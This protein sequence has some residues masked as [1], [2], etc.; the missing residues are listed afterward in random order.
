MKKTYFKYRALVT[1]LISFLPGVYSS[2][3]KLTAAG[4]GGTGAAR[5]CLD[6]WLSHLSVASKYGLKEIPKSI[7]ELGPG[8]SLGAGLSA[9]LLGAE[10]YFAMDLMPYSQQNTN[11]VVLN[12]L[13]ALIKNQK[14][15]A[16]APAFPE[17]A[18]NLDQSLWP[19]D[20]FSNEKF[21][22]LLSQERLSKIERALDN[23]NQSNTESIQ[24][25]YKAPWYST[26][27][28]ENNSIDFVFS[29]AVLEHVDDLASMHKSVFQFLKN[30]GMLVH[31]VDF[32]AHGTAS[33]WNGHWTI[34]KLL[35][36]LIRGKRPYS[37]NRKTLSQQKEEL[38]KAG[39]TIIGQE[40]QKVDG[41]PRQALSQEFKNMSD[42][43]LTCRQAFIV[44]IKN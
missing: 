6:C 41:V 10:K 26:N 11:K 2:L 23:I 24:I 30:G 43:D 19:K 42:Q 22:N 16:K 35:W 28:L 18:Q 37:I 34:S 33:I 4:S 9:V 39:F 7:V 1:G 44:A 12:E 21:A 20:F 5:Y 15:F 38:I 31:R 14:G 25:G 36:K 40:I 17:I 13:I 8:Q 3:Y 29:N 27:L 32:A